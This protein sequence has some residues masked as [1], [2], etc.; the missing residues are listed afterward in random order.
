MVYATFKST[1]SST[2][3]CDRIHHQNLFVNLVTPKAAT[4]LVLLINKLAFKD[5]LCNT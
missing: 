3:K 1:S 4:K 5:D 2:T